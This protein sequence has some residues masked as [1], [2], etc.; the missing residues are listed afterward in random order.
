MRQSTAAA[1]FW[2][3]GLLSPLGLMLKLM[4]IYYARAMSEQNPPELA[5]RVLAVV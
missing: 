2:G 1:F 3:D 5:S 4:L